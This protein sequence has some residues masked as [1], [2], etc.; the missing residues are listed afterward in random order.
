MMVFDDDPLVKSSNR[1]NVRGRHDGVDQ[2][3][4]MTRTK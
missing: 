1:Q 2:Y 4:Y 3:P